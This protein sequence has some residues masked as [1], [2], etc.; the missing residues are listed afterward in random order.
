MHTQVEKGGP[1]AHREFLAEGTSDPRRSFAEALLRALED[2]PWPVVVYSGFE[3]QVLGDL[4]AALPD[5]APRLGDVA[6][7]LFD[8]LPVVRS[9][10]YD[11]GF[12][13]S[14]SIKRVAPALVAGFG[15]GDLAE[16]ADGGRA[17]EVLEQLGRGG[18]E[19]ERV[20]ALRRSLLAYC[21]R[22]TLALATVHAALRELAGA[23]RAV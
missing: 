14:F 4:G 19:P 12:R 9:C 23:R 21:A 20:A 8:L 5:L 10:V 16:V 22:D 2:D 18:L 3:G 7:R 1:L 13:G 6:R 17:A 11:V 15:Y